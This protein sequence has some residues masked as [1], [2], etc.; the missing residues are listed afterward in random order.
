MKNCCVIFVLG[1]VLLHLAHAQVQH[2]SAFQVSEI[3]K[4][5]LVL[6]H[7]WLFYPEDDFR[8]AQI[9]F[10]GKKGIPV[11]PALLL[12]QLPVV[13]RSGIG[14]F[15]LAMRVD[16]SQRNKTVGM[17]I[18]LFGAAEIYL[19]GE[20]IYQFGEVSAD[21][22][23]EKTQ[24][25]FG[26]ALSLALGKEEKQVLAV[27]F[28]HH[29]KNRYVKTGVVPF[30]LRIVLQP[31]NESISDYAVLVKRAYQFIS[32]ALTI[33]LASAIL[34]LFFFFSFPSRKEYLFFGLYFSLNFLGVLVQIDLAGVGKS[35]QYTV[36]ELGLIQFLIFL[37]AITG[38]LFYL[39]GM[40]VLLQK[41]KTKFYWFLLLY[42]IV[43][44]VALPFMPTWGSGLP[45]MFFV[46]ACFEFLVI[47]YKAAHKHFRGAWILFTSV[48]L[49]L[50]SLIV[51]VTRNYANDSGLII[52]LTAL[53]MLTPALGIMVFLAI[54]FARTSLA[55]KSRIAEVESLSQ[56]ALAQEREKQEM[57]AAQK[58]ELERQVQHRTSELSKSLTNLKVTQSQ[59]IHSEKMASL[60]ELT[61]GV[62]HEIKN[63]LNFINNFSEVSNELLEEMERAL[64]AQNLDEVRLLIVS[65]KEN[66]RRIGEHGKR[67]DDIVKSMLQHSRKSTG[68]KEPTDINALVEEYLLLSYYGIRAKD[69]AFSAHLITNFD[70]D[71]GKIEIIPQEV[72]RVLLN[73]FNNAFYAINEKRKTLDGSFEPTLSVETRKAGDKVEISVHDNGTGIPSN[74]VGKV[75]QP[76]FTTKPT[77]K[78]TGLGLSLSYDIIT[79]GHNGKLMIE[80]KEGEWTKFVV[81]LPITS[82]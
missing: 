37:F 73:L 39:N 1:T 82:S 34:T 63:P 5:G 33:E 10:P 12:N 41:K 16:S 81:Q 66:L 22:K 26:R 19:N 20:R 21:Y 78:G 25:I 64:Q 23:Q 79:K 71:I 72:G 68:T 65:I 56:K 8:Y 52:V 35:V 70:K 45:E 43:S 9:D 58:D 7:N 57:L 69:N 60:G 40:Y 61:A 32:L 55:L 53:A 50:L 77:G 47:Y 76:F 2:D 11:N 17:M 49:S 59:L 80:S 62:A 4:D 18:S 67:A 13:E 29:P 54:D 36:N 75:C 74:I 3:P 44:I 15:R 6:D 51:L 24:A 14:W 28:S 27:R 31:L 38:T 48:L 30:C 46:L 42:A